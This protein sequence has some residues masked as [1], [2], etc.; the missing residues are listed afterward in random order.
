MCVVDATE[1]L[2]WVTVTGSTYIPQRL[3]AMNVFHLPNNTWLSRSLLAR[4]IAHWPSQW[5]PATDD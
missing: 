3:L 2:S 4:E 1:V 5:Y